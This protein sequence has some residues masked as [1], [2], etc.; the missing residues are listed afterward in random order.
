MA[1]IRPKANLTVTHPASGG[2]VSQHGYRKVWQP[3][4]KWQ[5]TWAEYIKPLGCLA[6]QGD[7]RP[8]TMAG[9]FAV[10]PDYNDAV[11]EAWGAGT[12][13]AVWADFYDGGVYAAG[14]AQA[15][16][17][18]GVYTD[19]ATDYWAP[20]LTVR[21]VR[22]AP[23]ATQGVVPATTVGIW[24]SVKVSLTAALTYVLDPVNGT[25]V[26]GQVTA[27]WPFF[28]GS[29]N[30]AYLAFR[31][32]RDGSNPLQIYS[33]HEYQGGMEGGLQTSTWAIEYVEDTTLFPGGHILIRSA[34]QPQEWWHTYNECIR[35]INGPIYCLF[36]GCKQ[37]VNVSPIYYSDDT[38]SYSPVAQ[39]E[40]FAKLPALAWNP[41]ATWAALSTASTGWTVTPAA[42]DAADVQLARGYRPKVTFDPGGAARNW[43]PVVWNLT[44]THAAVNAVPAGLP[45]A[46]S[47][48]GDKLLRELE[49][50]VDYTWRN[51]K[52][53]AEFHDLATAQYAGW[54]DGSPVT[55]NFGWQTG[56]GA[57]Y[58][59]RDMARAYILRG[60]LPRRRAGSVSAGRPQLSAELGD[61]IAHR[62]K[63]T[64]VVDVGPVAGMLFADWAA[65][66]ANR[67]ALDSSLVT[68]DAS[69]TAASLRI[70]VFQPIPSKPHLWPQDGSSWEQHLEEVCS[71]CNVRWGWNASG[72]FFDLG[73]AAYNPGVSTISATL[74]QSVKTHE[75]L[76]T[77]IETE[78]EGEYR[79][80]FKGIYGSEKDSRKPLYYYA[81]AATLQENGGDWWAVIDDQDCD[82]PAAVVAK[83]WKE[84]GVKTIIHWTGLLKPG[85]LPDQ[86]VQITNVTELGLTD[87]TV[88]RV[89]RH[90]WRLCNN[91]V[92]AQSEI[93]AA[94]VY[95]PGGQ[96][97]A[98]L[99]SASA[100]GIEPGGA[101]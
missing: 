69:I 84:H 34:S 87:N 38:G 44:Q 61:W 37:T 71:A 13:A 94:L 26:D 27:T 95:T 81:D 79:N 99:A 75:G 67:L 57:D 45:A 77:E 82:T 50:T 96:A 33:S 63:S 59:A 18:G 85:L 64:K 6:P 12:P 39:P 60:G 22:A 8:R 25:W 10:H 100:G 65:L 53:R 7:L 73:P 16:Y 92:E 23:P 30:K 35:L 40:E 15:A 29:A 19:Q 90:R 20:N 47:T 83:F 48:E 66:V 42:A 51:A 49:W 28:G 74:D 62:L 32:G 68:V 88:W 70:P 36:G 4:E 9:V 17:M 3:S 41:T 31:V 46:E 2:V 52:G 11:R 5:G 1:L 24:A 56:A 43:R 72:L 86:F 97:G 58:V 76:F 14:T 55:V 54:K 98:G 89:I 101:G 91:P 78:L 80:C 21:M 93:T